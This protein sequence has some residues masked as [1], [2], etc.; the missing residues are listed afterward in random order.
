MTVPE[1]TP[2]SSIDALTGRLI[3]DFAERRALRAGSFIVT[4]YGDVVLPRGGSLWIGNV[5]ETCGLV[6]I[7]ETLAR[8][9]V[10][11]LVEAGRLAGVREGRRSFYRLTESAAAEFETA[12][13]VLHAPQD[14][15]EAEWTLVVLS[16]EGRAAAQEALLRRGFGAAAPGLAV[17]PGDAAAEARS[18][19]PTSAEAVIFRGAPETN[20]APLAG[21]VAGAW[22]LPALAE[23]YA[24]FVARF[25]PV[26]GA[27][28]TGAAPTSATSLALRLLLV[29]DFRA[30]ALRDPGLPPETLPASWPGAAARALFRRLYDR[31]TPAAEAFVAREFVA[32]DGP[33]GPPTGGP[34]ASLL[35]G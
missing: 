23:R 25:M 21:F 19:L 12:A 3:A 6:G 35:T 33:L 16:G 27:L 22:D 17:K 14:V 30:I 29:H 31:L 24:G 20:G 11:R 18:A 2:Q 5:I 28:D 1:I 32:L 13:R 4:I 8:T 10:S 9:A 34:A 7:S 26:A 15:S